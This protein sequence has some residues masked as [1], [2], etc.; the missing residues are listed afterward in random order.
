MI[1]TALHADLNNVDL[2]LPYLVTHLLNLFVAFYATGILTE[3][4]A[5]G[6]AQFEEVLFS[7]DRAFSVAHQAVVLSGPNQIGISIE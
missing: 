2:K 7:A 6:V 5:E 3:Q 1:P 4:V